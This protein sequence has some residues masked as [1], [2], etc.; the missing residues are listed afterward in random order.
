MF[1]GFL[2]QGTSLITN[3]IIGNRTDMQLSRLKKLKK[4]VLEGQISTDQSL[5]V[6]M[7]T[8]NSTYIKVGTIEGD[9]SYTLAE[10]EYRIGDSEIG[11][12][13]IAGPERE[14]N[15]ISVRHYKTE[16]KLS[17]PKFNNLNYKLVATGLG[18]V[19]VS[20]IEY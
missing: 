6:Y 1:K 7:C 18:Y 19:S 20:L 14:E 12:R 3:Y 11:D 9:G 4:I 5:D 17:L 16:I 15:Y 13:E 8:D 2:D 10:S